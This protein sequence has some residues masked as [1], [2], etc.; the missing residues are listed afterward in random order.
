MENSIIFFLVGLGLGY[1]VKSNHASS[2][3]DKHLES[4]V[5]ELE[6]QIKYYK[7]LTRDL[8]E[9]NQSIRAMIR[10]KEQVAY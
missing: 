4:Q 10:Q 2:G 1:L 9:E 7:K 6:R 8:S 3:S 5:E